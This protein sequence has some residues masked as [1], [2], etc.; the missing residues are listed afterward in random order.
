MKSDPITVAGYARTPMG[1]LNGV[2]AGLP[3]PALGASAIRAAIERAG[4]PA[5]EQ[6]V[7]GCVLTAG[8]GP[9]PARQAAIRA[10]LSEA[11]P[12]LTVN[13]MCGSGMAAIILAH[14]SLLAGSAE[15]VVA[16][17]M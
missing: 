13:K 8:Q 14:D 15:T 7:M 3:A 16:G 5:I 9:A 6:V 11:I 1:S 12:A 10:G 4:R 17:G 2:F